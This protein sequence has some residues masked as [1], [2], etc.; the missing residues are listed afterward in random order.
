MKIKKIVDLSE[1]LGDY[2][3]CWAINSESKYTT[4][5]EGDFTVST[6]TMNV[7]TGTHVDSPMHRGGWSHAPVGNQPLNKFMGFAQVL[8]GRDM[9]FDSILPST[10]IIL[11]KNEYAY[12]QRYYTEGERSWPWLDTSVWRKLVNEYGIKAVGVD[13]PSIDG[14]HLFAG[15]GNNNH[16]FLSRAGVPI[17]ETLRNLEKLGSVQFWFFGLPLNFGT[18]EASP[19]RAVGIIEDEE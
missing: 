3:T 12:N 6:I 14:R 19:V 18:L 4:N 1:D 11:V 13:S 8:E 10:E 16:L 17:F 9:N 5:S 2:T 7:H 15:R